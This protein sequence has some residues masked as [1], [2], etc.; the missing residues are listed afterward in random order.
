MHKYTERVRNLLNHRQEK[1]DLVGVRG[2][3]YALEPGATWGDS[4]VVEIWLDLHPVIKARM[5][6]GPIDTSR[7]STGVTV[8]LKNGDRAVIA[9]TNDH[10]RASGQ[11][12]VMLLPSGNID[13]VKASTIKRIVF[14][15]SDPES[16]SAD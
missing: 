8:E 13:V 15:P 2:A 9:P 16:D 6:P 5:L 4:A 11:I 1:S 10:V 12:N 7:F 3:L 14:E